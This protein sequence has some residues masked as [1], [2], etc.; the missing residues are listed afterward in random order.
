[1]RVSSYFWMELEAEE[2][3]GWL[4]IEETISWRENLHGVQTGAAE[5]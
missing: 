2:S 3:H 5:W 4:G 1:M